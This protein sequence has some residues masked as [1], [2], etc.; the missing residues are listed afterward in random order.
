MIREQEIDAIF[1]LSKSKW[2]MNFHKLCIQEM[3]KLMKIH[4]K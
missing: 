2:E 3:E 1:H 4:L